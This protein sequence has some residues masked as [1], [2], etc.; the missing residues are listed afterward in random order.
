MPLGVGSHLSFWLLDVLPELSPLPYVRRKYSRTLVSP[1]TSDAPYDERSG[2]SAVHTFRRRQTVP[3]SLLGRRRS[4]HDEE[5]LASPICLVRQKGPRLAKLTH[6]STSF[7]EPFQ[8]SVGL[9]SLNCTFLGCGASYYS[10]WGWEMAKSSSKAAEK[11]EPETFA[12]TKAK[13]KRLIVRNFRSIGSDPVTVDLDDIVVLVG[14]NNAGKS[15]ILRAYEV[16]MSHG[17]SEGKLELHDFPNEK[18]NPDN[19]PEI[20]LQTYVWDDLPAEQWLHT[21][22]E[23]GRKYIRERWRWSEAGKDP[24]RQGHRA[25]AEDW[26]DDVPWGAPNVAKSRRPRPHRVDAFASPEDQGEKLS[27]LLQEI[28]SDKAE[29]TAG[30]EKSVLERLTAEIQK[31]QK[32]IVEQSKDDIDGIAN[33]LSTYIGEIFVG[34]KVTLDAQPEQISDKAI[35]LFA[36]RPIIR[37][38]PDGGHMA[39][40]DKQGSGARRTLL[41]S[42]LKIAS[43]RQPEAKKVKKTDKGAVAGAGDAPSRPH[44]LLL[45]EPEICLHPAA[46]RDACRVLYDLAANGTGWQVMVTTHSPTFIDVSR[47]NTTVVRVERLANGSISGT[48]VFRP[49]TVKL[50]DNDKQLLKLLNQW[51]PYV[52]E[53]FFGGRT[54]VVEGDTEYSSFREIT[55]EDPKKYRDVHIVRARGK[56]IIPIL[57]KILNHF[58]G[59][60]AVLHDSDRPRIKNGNKNPAWA[61]NQSILDAANAVAD[62]A[63]V[64]IAASLID[65][66]WAVFGTSESSNKPFEAVQ[67]IRKD[68]DAKDRVRKALDYLIFDA[69]EPPKGIVRWGSADELEKLV[70][71]VGE[72][73]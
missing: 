32:Q 30:D 15:T 44:V 6:R 25:T 73:A 72:G 20:E 53:F 26:D 9:K 43:D 62:K 8:K 27:K 38:G 24:K 39:P 50:S 55:E 4:I 51:D 22:D 19:L 33:S 16:V 13:V 65:F 31:L 10:I 35:N 60:Y 64:R 23:T 17:S 45:D 69:V 5:C 2:L 54:V 7:Y 47:D 46:I 29:K 42:A 57:M 59:R 61:A 21:E 58:G 52:G 34:F 67:K 66:E 11:A 36:S 71:Q 12:L 37:M 28:L 3:P 41:W 14:P 18:V 49:D 63:K 70:G 40:L 56:F 48:T 68:A 1:R